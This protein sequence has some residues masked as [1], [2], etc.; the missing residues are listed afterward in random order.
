MEMSYLLCLIVL[1]HLSKATRGISSKCPLQLQ[2][3]VNL[4]VDFQI[5]LVLLFFAC[6]LIAIVVL[7]LIFIPT[8][9]V[10][11][12]TNPSYLLP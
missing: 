4:A 5:F 7:L 2:I 8:L 9:F 3:V 6:V 1:R 12:S 11:L 10:W